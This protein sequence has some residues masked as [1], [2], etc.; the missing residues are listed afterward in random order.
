MEN[1]SR[2]ITAQ[3]QLEVKSLPHNK[4]CKHMGYEAFC[5]YITQYNGNII[6]IITYASCGLLLNTD[7]KPTGFKTM[8]IT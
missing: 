2:K 7:A 5:K 4:L 8:L 6:Y 3:I 1:D